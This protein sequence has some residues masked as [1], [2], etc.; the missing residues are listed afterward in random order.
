MTPKSIL[1]I[2]V[3]RI[4]DTLLATPAIR[5]LAAAWPEAAIDVLAHPGRMEVLQHLPFIRHVAAISKK[6]APFRG[7]GGLLARPYDLAVVYGY[8]EALVAYALRVAKRVAAFRQSSARINSRLAVMV[9]PPPFQSDHSVRLALALPAALGVKPA[10]LRLSYAVTAAERT[11]AAA[12]LARDLPLGAAPVVGL[13][14]ASFPTKAYRDWPIESFMELCERIRRDWPRAHFLIFGGSEEQPRTEA[15][16]AR[17]GPAATLYAGRLSLR[18]TGALMSRLDIFIGVDTGPTHL[19]SAFDIPLV[20]LYH[21]FS[22]SELIAPLEHP[23]FYPV[24]HPLAGPECSTEA[25]MADISVDRVWAAV[26]Q[27]LKEHPAQ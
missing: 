14:V 11:W 20:G 23:C 1:V 3:S 24:D 6:S 13:Q 9:E 7:W 2:N 26:Q 22:R 5:A 27:A 12:T 25:S 19:M 10:G 21:G 4:G 17:L 8:D 18:Q 16:K 15:L